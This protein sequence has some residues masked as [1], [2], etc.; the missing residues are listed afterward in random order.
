MKHAV[1]I[2]LL[3]IALMNAPAFAQQIVIGQGAAYGC[4]QSALSDNPGTRGAIRDCTDALDDPLS[5]RDEAATR[6]NRGLLL[7][8]KGDHAA[9]LS[10][11]AAALRI[12]PDLPEAHVNRGTALFHTGEMDAARDAYTRAIDLGIGKMP[13]ALYN[14]ALIHER[15]DNARAAYSDL[16]AALALR[17]D[18]DLAQRAIGRFTVVRRAN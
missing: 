18:W 1:P 14:R 2:A 5:L 12:D 17:P 9:A 13:E 11:Y 4:Y 15:Q 10:D 16:K 8:R 3:A 7:M 6:V